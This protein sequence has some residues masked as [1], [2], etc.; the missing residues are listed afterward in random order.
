MGGR[1]F[2]ATRRL[3]TYRI[4]VRASHH[5]CEPTRSGGRIGREVL[6]AIRQVRSAMALFLRR[7]LSARASKTCAHRR[8]G[9][10]LSGSLGASGE[11]VSRP[12]AVGTRIIP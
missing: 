12:F 6:R 8:V 9:L 7:S 5:T 11:Q 1:G 10:S 3:L 2:T 4:E